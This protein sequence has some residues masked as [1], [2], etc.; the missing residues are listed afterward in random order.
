VT[1]PTTLLVLLRRSI[2]VRLGRAAII[3]LAVALASAV[4]SALLNLYSEVDAKLHHEFRRFGANAVIATRDNS[5]SDLAGALGRL[6]YPAVPYSYVAAK[7]VQGRPVVVAGTEIPAALQ[8]NPGWQLE[9]DPPTPRV[10]IGKRVASALGTTDLSFRYAGKTFHIASAAILST[11]G[12][13]D[14]RIYIPSADFFAW[15]GI[16]VSVIELSI[17]GSPSEVEQSLSRLQRDFP[18]FDVRPVRQLVEAETRVLDRTRSLLTAATILIAVLITLC[19]L[20]TLTSSVLERRRDFALMK[21]LGSSYQTIALLF[22]G[23]TCAVAL[24][25]SLFGFAIGIGISQ[26]IGRLNFHAAF[27]VHLTA[28]PYV[29]MGALLIAA[30]GSLLPLVSLRRIQPAVMLKGE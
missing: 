25:G 26:I 15:T 9:N 19:V 18:Q 2:R 30:C 27:D 29:L 3:F 16:P 23:E 4:A 20:A 22:L 5:H 1:D 13:E 6:P 10:L 7:D 17:P 8:M 28:L 24:L 21:A 11:G 14:S 12:P